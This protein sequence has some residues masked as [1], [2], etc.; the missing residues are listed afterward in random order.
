M[1]S[2]IFQRKSGIALL[3]LHLMICLSTSIQGQTQIG[4]DIIGEAD[5]DRCGTAV[6]MPDNNTIAVGAYANDGNGIS[7]GHVRIYSWNGS[8]WVQKGADIDG[9]AATGGPL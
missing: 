2:D 1:P 4:T 3:I 9:E 5:K 7:A 6:S 8:A